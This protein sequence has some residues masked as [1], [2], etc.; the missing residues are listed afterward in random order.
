MDGAGSQA[1]C[2]V[3]CGRLA[4][5]GV[6]CGRVASGPASKAKRR[7]GRGQENGRPARLSAGEYAT[8]RPRRVVVPGPEMVPG[9]RAVD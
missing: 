2:V 3:V 6:K 8:I 5:Y 4:R 9:T 7:R 1:R